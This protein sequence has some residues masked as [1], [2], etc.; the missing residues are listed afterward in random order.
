MLPY[1]DLTT[2]TEAPTGLDLSQIVPAGTQAQ[3]NAAVQN[4][5]ERASSWVDG[6]CYQRIAA[7]TDQ[8]QKRVRPNREGQL[9]IFSKNFPVIAVLGA[10]YIDLAAGA[11][12]TYTAID[13]TKIVPLERSFL[14]YD[15]D[16][17]YWRAWGT[18]P[19]VVQYQYTNGYP[20]TT[21]TGP[22]VGTSTVVAPGSATL[23]VASTVG[24][25]TT[26]GGAAGWNTVSEL[27]ILDGATR[28]VV[29][30]TAINGTT[31][32][33]AAP[34]VNA[35]SLGAL[36]SGVPQIVQ[37]ATI[38]AATWM[39]KNPRG[40]GSFVMPGAGGTEKKTTAKTTDDDLLE[41]AHTMLSPFRR[42]L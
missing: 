15:K 19:L 28:E 34:T 32:T 38:L 11:T 27:E 16:Y 30:V 8:G 9:E 10:S 26:G 5:L 20:L 13:I 4:L 42:V 40:D 7:T 21:I 39:V 41:R 1:I 22:V 37:E 3:Q 36:V 31:L 17:S 6:D 14:I 23:N 35:H 33:L 29:Q 25:G 12:A 18:N 2:F 24:I